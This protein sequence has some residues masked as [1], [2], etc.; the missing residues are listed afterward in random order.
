MYLLLSYIGFT[1]AIFSD[2]FM[3]LFNFIKDISYTLSDPTYIYEN[4]FSMLI[5][6]ILFIIPI[7][8]LLY[9]STKSVVNALIIFAI[10]IVIVY[11]L[12]PQNNVI[13]ISGGD[14][15]SS[16]IFNIVKSKTSSFLETIRSWF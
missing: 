3:S 10:S 13:P 1:Y 9:D 5:P 14:S 6:I 15:P 8:V 4:G 11:F 16:S 12:Y 7:F 2:P